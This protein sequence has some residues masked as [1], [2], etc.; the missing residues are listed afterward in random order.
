MDP[1]IGPNVGVHGSDT[2][3]LKILMRSKDECCYGH[4]KDDQLFTQYVSSFRQLTMK[5]SE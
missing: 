2:D 4:G 5:L 1:T 3:S